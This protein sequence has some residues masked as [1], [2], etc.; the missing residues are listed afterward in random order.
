MKLYHVVSTK[1][2]R[3]DF[4]R[5]KKSGMDTK[6]L[7]TVIDMLANGTAL[8]EQYRDHPLKFSLDSTRECHIGPDW[9][10]VYVKHERDLV[11]LLVR[12]GTHRD[13]LGIE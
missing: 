8:P 2:Y 11:L 4:K 7:D 12:T 9:L 10:L 3:K 5:L 1:Q 6:K 13:A